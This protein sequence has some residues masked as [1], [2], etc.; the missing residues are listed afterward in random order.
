MTKKDDRHQNSQNLVATI[1]PG[2]RKT[3][4]EET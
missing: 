4:Q 1:I 2:Q 3:K